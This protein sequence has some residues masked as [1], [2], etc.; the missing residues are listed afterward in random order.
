MRMRLVMRVMPW[1]ISGHC[2]PVR[3]RR[4]RCCSP[5]SA[6][7]G[8]GAGAGGSVRGPSTMRLVRSVMAVAMIGATCSA[9]VSCAKARVPDGDHG[10][11]ASDEPEVIA[12]GRYLVRGP[13]HCAACHGDPASEDERRLGRDV[14]LSGGRTFHLGLLGSIVAPNITSDPVAGIGSLSDHTLVRSLRHGIS[15]QGR[16]LAPFMPFADLADDDLRAILSFLRAL[17]PVAQRVSATDLTWLGTF[18]I[19]VLGPPGPTAPPPS[20]VT[21]AR[22]AMYGRYL[23]HTVA[24]CH[25]CHT[26][27]SRLTG[28]F[29]GPAFAGGLA[30]TE[31]AGAFIPPNVTAGAGGVLNGLSESDFIARF[32]IDGRGRLGSPMPWEAFARMTDD[33]LGAI[34]RYLKTLTSGDAGRSAAGSSST[35]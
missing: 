12:R 35:P 9:L 27:R 26:R 4:A 18:V 30:I 29:V 24:S 1:R 13:A 23:A 33:D 7:S 10:I 11:Q 15:R 31:R 32:R 16:P 34:Y 19:D 20:S 17:P 8:L 21:P 28:A 3:G 6:R 22:N 2:A 25:G 14:P 5:G